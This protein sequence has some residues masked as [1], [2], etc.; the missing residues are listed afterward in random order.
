MTRIFMRRPYRLKLPSGA[1]VTFVK[2]CYH[3]V[4]VDRL[5]MLPDDTYYFVDSQGQFLIPE[6]P[7]EDDALEAETEVEP[8]PLE[9]LEPEGEPEKPEGETEENDLGFFDPI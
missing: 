1:V 8:E 6:E 7:E 3:Q 9:P 4:P 2:D 5:A